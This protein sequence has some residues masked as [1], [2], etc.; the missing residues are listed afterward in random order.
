MGWLKEEIQKEKMR[1]EGK[2]NHRFRKEMRHVKTHGFYLAQQECKGTINGCVSRSSSRMNQGSLFKK[3]KETRGD[4]LEVPAESA[5]FGGCHKDLLPRASG[6]LEE[7]LSGR[8][9]KQPR[10]I[11][12]LG[13]GRN[14]S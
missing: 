11:A 12:G 1:D 3:Q 4:G 10:L 6:N 14:I 5:I 8:E 2:R 13:G 7:N 9:T